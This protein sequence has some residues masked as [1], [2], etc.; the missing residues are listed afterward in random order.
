LTHMT[1]RDPADVAAYDEALARITIG[2]P[3]H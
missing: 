3:G 2:A 1:P